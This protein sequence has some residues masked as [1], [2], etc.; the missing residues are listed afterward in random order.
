[1]SGMTNGTGKDVFVMERYGTRPA[2]ASFLPG[3]AGEWGIPVWCY[4]ANRGQAVC[5]FGLSD[6]DHAIMEFCPAHVAWQNVRRT[7]FRTFVKRRGP[8]G[9]ETFTEAFAD[10][11]ADMA[12]RPNELTLSWTDGQTRVEVAYFVLPGCQV[13][14]LV[15]QV[16][17]TNLGGEAAID[18]LDGMP[19]LVPAG[20][21]QDSLKNMTQLS[22]AWM[23]AE[24]AVPDDPE[25]RW[26]IYRVRYS[27]E[28]AAT[29]H[30][31]RACHFARHRL[32]QL[33][34]ESL[35]METMVSGSV[36]LV[37]VAK[38]SNA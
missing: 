20:V 24:D 3:I 33:L 38:Q 21:G 2:F 11:H 28:D 18:L 7:G 16:T 12:I 36:T 37:R 34:N 30:E 5:S 4:Y 1:M 32:E 8:D 35:P 17:L 31:I 27:M 13:G 26:A 6:K 29:I 25:K 19:A 22:K 10:D 15:R 23:Q 9:T 14:A